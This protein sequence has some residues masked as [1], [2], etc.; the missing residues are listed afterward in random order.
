MCAVNKNKPGRA[1]TRK[2]LNPNSCLTS[3]F[4]PVFPWK[5]FLERLN[6][7]AGETFACTSEQNG[8]L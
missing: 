2:N 1:E 6:G 5:E 3:T 4:K 8:A 7:K